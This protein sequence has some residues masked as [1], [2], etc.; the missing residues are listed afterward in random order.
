MLPTLVVAEF[1]ATCFIYCMILVFVPH[2][3]I[4][5]SSLSSPS[6]SMGAVILMAHN[7]QISVLFPTQIPNRKFHPSLFL[8]HNLYPSPIDTKTNPPSFSHHFLSKSSSSS[9]HKFRFHFILL[10]ESGAEGSSLI[11]AASDA[12]TTDFTALTR[13]FAQTIS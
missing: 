8:T 3:K 13:F 10:T 5:N 1:P 4:R 11:Q 6:S 12:E 7:N 2:L 9:Y